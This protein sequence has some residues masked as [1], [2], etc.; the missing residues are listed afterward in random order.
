MEMFAALH[1]FGGMRILLYFP[2]DLE[3]VAEILNK[4][5]FIVRRVEKGDGSRI[6]L[7]ALKDRLEFLKDPRRKGQVTTTQRDLNRASRTL[8]GY[9]STHFVVK[10]RDHDIERGSECTWKD[11]VVEIQ[12]ETLMMHAWSEVEH[13]MVYKPVISG[14]EGVS[15]D[16]K[17]ILD[18]INGIV[19]AGEAALRQLEVSTIKRSAKT[20]KL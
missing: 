9:R 3:K 16:E 15:S 6:N 4:H 17:R 8:K 10:L 13:G 5:F 12:V 19:L 18:S 7:Q 20:P 2:G 11:L 14:G 1:D